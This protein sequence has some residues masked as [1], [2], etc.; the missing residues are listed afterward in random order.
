[1]ELRMVRLVLEAQEVLTSWQGRS[2]PPVF[3]GSSHSST[4]LP[5]AS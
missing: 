2:D 3:R 1:L 5:G 4:Q